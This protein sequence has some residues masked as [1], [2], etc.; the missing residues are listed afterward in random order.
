MKT[1][2]KMLYQ[3]MVAYT[4]NHGPESY[5]NLGYVGT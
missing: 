3:V 4:Y 5:V 2:S 1:C